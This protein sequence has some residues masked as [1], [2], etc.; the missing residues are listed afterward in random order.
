MPRQPNICIFA[1]EA[2][3]V[4]GLSRFET[5]EDA[6]AKVMHRNGLFTAKVEK[7]QKAV[8]RVER[9]A[10][11][12]QA[13]VRAA[14]PEE[15]KAIEEKI[16]AKVAFEHKI[17]PTAIKKQ[18]KTNINVAHGTKAEPHD[19][20]RHEQITNKEVVRK[21]QSCAA[22]LATPSGIRYKVFGRIDGAK[23]GMLTEFKRRRNRLFGRIP[24]Y[25]MP[26]LYVYMYATGIHEALQIETFQGEQLEHK[27]MFDADTWRY[28][29][30][31]LN[32]AVER[33]IT[34]SRAK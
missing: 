25:E 28:Y 4:M 11:L 8:E 21:Q 18:I 29:E 31:L 23:D 10:A 33:M 7:K 27:V 20:R 34:D 12:V 16:V 22:D 3:A 24:D 6:I 30:E 1:S 2:A 26:Q 17:E 5:Q 9:A 13:R 32:N 15:R 14:P 19:I